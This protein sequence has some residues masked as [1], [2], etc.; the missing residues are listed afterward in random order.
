M[1][2]ANGFDA[3]IVRLKPQDVK[4][5]VGMGHKTPKYQV[6]AMVSRILRVHHIH[7]HHASDALACAIAGLIQPIYRVVNADDNQ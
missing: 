6:L 3:E 1:P 2:H 4:A 5:A 7:K